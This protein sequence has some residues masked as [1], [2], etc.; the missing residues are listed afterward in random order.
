[1]CRYI[2]MPN[3]IFGQRSSIGTQKP[4][5]VLIRT[6][7]LMEKDISI[8]QNKLCLNCACQKRMMKRPVAS[9][10]QCLHVSIQ[11]VMWLTHNRA[12]YC[13]ATAGCILLLPQYMYVKQHACPVHLDLSLRGVKQSTSLNTSFQLFCE[14]SPPDSLPAA[15]SLVALGTPNEG[16]SVND[17]SCLISC[18]VAASTRRALSVEGTMYSRAGWP[19]WVMLLAANAISKPAT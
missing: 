9:L 7:Y 15:V 13:T 19:M 1:M 2:L 4:G 16:T 12:T 10:M 11:T 5:I 3:I 14:F 6:N 8:R 18:L 17:H